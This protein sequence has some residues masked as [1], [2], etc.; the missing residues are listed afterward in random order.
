MK[1]V[2][3]AVI[4]TLLL[5]AGSTSAWDGDWT[6]A[7]SGEWP[8]YDPGD[9]T[10]TAG[11]DEKPQTYF[12]PP[13][14]DFDDVDTEELY[15]KVKDYS[16]HA[17]AQFTRSVRVS[18]SSLAKGYY[19]VRMGQ[20][21]DG[22]N[23]TN[24]GEIRPVTPDTLKTRQKEDKK[25]GYDVFVIYKLGNVAAVCP[26]QHRERYEK[27]EGEKL[28]KQPVAWLDLENNQPVLKFYYDKTVYTSVL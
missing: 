4:F 16:P 2:V 10:G 5:G 20:A 18:G 12:I 6:R 23:N 8:A 11:T 13:S 24:L 28:P 21:G 3:S 19:L 1:H 14:R 15:R 7:K 27:Q 17:L 26:I 22:S 9:S 25:A